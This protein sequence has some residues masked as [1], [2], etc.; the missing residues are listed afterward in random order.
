MNSRSKTKTLL[1]SIT[2]L[3]RYSNVGIDQIAG[4]LR[5]HNFNIDIYYKHTRADADTIFSE[6]SLDY[7]VYGFS[8]T[9]A[10]YECCC[11]LSTLIKERKPDALVIFGGGYPTRYY[12]E[13]YLENDSV[14]YIILGDG[15]L[16]FENLLENVFSNKALFFDENIVKKGD[17]EN[18]KPYC[19]TV[20][21]YFPAFD[22]FENDS[23][24]RNKRKEYCIQT[25]NNVCTGKCT[26]CTERKGLIIY[27]SIDHIIHEIETVH[28]KFGVQKFFF[29]DD[30]ILDPNNSTAKKRMFELCDR[31]QQLKCNIVFK[32]YIKANSLVD[33]EEDHRLLA[34]M[35]HVGFKTVFVGLESGNE[36]DLK[37]YNKLTTVDNNYTIIHMLRKYEIA[38]QIGFINL[39]PYSTL[40]TLK[41]NYYF[42]TAIEIDNLFMYVC[43]YMR[44]YKYTAMHD[45]ITRDN[46]IIPNNDY[47]DDKSMYRFADNDV[48]KIFDFINRYMFDRVRNL[49]FEFDWLYSFYLE[50]KSMNPI[51]VKYQEDF[52]RLRTDQLHKIK[53]F[54]NI[55][56]VEN[57]I[58][59]CETKVDDFLNYFESLQPIFSRLHKNLLEL[60]IS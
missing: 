29:T 41:Q 20:I 4:Y 48:Q 19:N 15:E 14:D 59:K 38:P 22:Y 3:W 54:F 10:N 46:L 40:E 32:C 49:D 24:S 8:V 12:K 23:W 35:S 6:L 9:S 44:V 27:K 7:D 34:K 30:N 58:K 11:R 53:V 43:S 37:L 1:I 18:K 57:D 16:P 13:I 31:I 26:F 52:D 50:C 60:Y 42:L 51:A 55:L 2:N 28:R 56:F 17:Y 36:R 5:N 45:M 39:N 21:D 25:K 33:S 47:L